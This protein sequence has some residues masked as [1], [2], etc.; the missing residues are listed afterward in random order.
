[1]FHFV[2][3]TVLPPFISFSPARITDE[4]RKTQLTLYKEYL[5]KAATLIPIYKA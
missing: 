5:E 2:G 4:E 3:M 1:M